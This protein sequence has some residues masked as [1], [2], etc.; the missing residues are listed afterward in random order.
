MLGMFRFCVKLHGVLVTT[1]SEDGLSA[2]ATKISTPLIIDSYTSDMCLQFWDMSSYARTM[3]ELQADVELKDTIM[4]AMPK[5]TREGFYTCIVRVEYLWKPSRCAC[6][7]VLGH[8]LDECPNNIDSDVVKNMKN[9]SQ[10]PKGV[11]VGPKVGFK[12]V[13]QVYRQ[14]ARKNN[15]NTNGNKKK[16]VEPTIE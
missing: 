10:N 1:F 16:D 8:Y 6:C 12:P 3:I 15:V 14:F 4:V 7:K 5:L 11:S 2:I 9:P 13:K